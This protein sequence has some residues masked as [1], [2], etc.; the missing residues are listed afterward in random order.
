MNILRNLLLLLDQ[1]FHQ[2]LSGHSL[3]KCK[4][5]KVFIVGLLW[6]DCLFTSIL[7]GSYLY[8]IATVEWN[9]QLLSSSGA[10]NICVVVILTINLLHLI[11]RVLVLIAIIINLVYILVNCTVTYIIIQLRL[12]L[13]KGGVDEV[14][15]SGLCSLL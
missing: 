13:G 4:L 15:E 10:L 12:C 5:L 2:L 1:W 6:R 8:P 7:I 3:C 9:Y 11:P 14:S